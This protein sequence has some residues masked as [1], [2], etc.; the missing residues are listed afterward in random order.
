MAP[1]ITS[2]DF[3]P[4]IRPGF[5]GNPIVFGVGLSVQDSTNCADHINPLNKGTGTGYPIIEFRGVGQCH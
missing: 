5:Y 3:Y 1:P 4:C 2:L